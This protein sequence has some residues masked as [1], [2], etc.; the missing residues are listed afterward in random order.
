MQPH[1]TGLNTGVI[2]VLGTTLVWHYA[3][4][5]CSLG[6]ETVSMDPLLSFLEL[7]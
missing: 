5:L 4:M 2:K 1:S 7:L 6:A 3:K